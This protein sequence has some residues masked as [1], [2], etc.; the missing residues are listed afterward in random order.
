MDQE[1]Q[2]Q[3]RIQA[4]QAMLSG[5]VSSL[6]LVP[7]AFKYSWAWDAFKFTAFLT[8]FVPAG[9]WFSGKVLGRVAR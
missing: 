4:R 2:K 3:V 7:L 5:V 6:L 1:T 9:I 8:F